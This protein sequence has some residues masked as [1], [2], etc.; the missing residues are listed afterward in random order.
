[1]QLVTLYACHLTPDILNTNETSHK[2]LL[3]K[4][5]LWFKIVRIYV[6]PENTCVTI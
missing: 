6:V 3:I 5:T 4:Y 1:M 2:I